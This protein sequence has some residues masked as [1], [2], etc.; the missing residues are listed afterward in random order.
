MCVA[1][2]MLAAPHLTS[3]S[4][5]VWAGCPPPSPF[6]HFSV[7]WLVWGTSLAASVSAPLLTCVP[8]APTALRRCSLTYKWMRSCRSS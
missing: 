2:C 3:V 4:G 8:T 1:V 6:P 5:C 7:C